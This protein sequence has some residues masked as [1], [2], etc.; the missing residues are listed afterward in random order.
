MNALSSVLSVCDQ[1]LVPEL[2]LEH[3]EEGLV[4]CQS[5]CPSLRFILLISFSL[6]CWKCSLQWSFFLNGM[7]LCSYLIPIIAVHNG[8]VV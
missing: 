7:F 6:I 1:N 2:C 5:L 3:L 8:P 4:Y